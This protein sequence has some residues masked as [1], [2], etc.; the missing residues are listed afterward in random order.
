MGLLRPASPSARSP[1][2]DVFLILYF[3]FFASPSSA[4]QNQLSTTFE[5]GERSVTDSLEDRDLSGNL[6]FNRYRLRVDGELSKLTEYTLWYERYDKNYQT[7][8]SLDSSSDEW[9]FGL[10]HSFLEKALKA[11]LDAGF[12]Q[13]DY[14]DSPSS[15]YDRSNAAIGLQYKD[16]DLWGINWA[17]GFINYD[18]TGSDRD[19]LKLFA[20]IGSWVKLFDERL[21]ISPSYKFQKVDDDDASKDRTEQV[22]TVIPVYKLGL[23]RLETISGYYSLGQNDTKDY[24][25]EDRDDDLRFSYVKWYLVTRHPVTERLDT[26]FKYGQVRRDYKN[27]DND[28]RNWG[29]ENKTGYKIFEDKIKKIGFSTVLEHKEADYHLADSLN[30]VKN[31]AG[32]EILYRQKNNWEISPSFRFKTYDYS[33]SPSRNERQYE[34]RVEFIKELLNDALALNIAYKYV[35]KDYRDK[36][37]VTLWSVKA[38]VEWKF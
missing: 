11:S 19:Q 27:S 32:A 16:E 12:R 30:Y 34:G 13:K 6:D 22:F 26:S 36:S 17:G 25:D 8:D 24:E 4:F 2:N 3:I 20:K 35:W 15:S 1:R 38:G 37:D 14:K 7:L 33:A 23:K 18:Y 31:V 10:D 9:H 21:K 28:Y 29:V 5:T